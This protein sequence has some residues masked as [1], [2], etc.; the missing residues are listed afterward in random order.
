MYHRQS[1]DGGGM[2]PDGDGKRQWD[3]DKSY[4]GKW[5]VYDLSLRSSAAR[6]TAFA[7]G[8]WTMSINGQNTPQGSACPTMDGTDVIY[9]T[10]HWQFQDLSWNYSY[11]NFTTWKPVLVMAYELRTELYVFDFTTDW[12][13][14]RSGRFVISA[15]PYSAQ[16][17]SDYYCTL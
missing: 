9:G 7:Y 2:N 13:G 11:D 6:P 15:R 1:L 3:A 10:F 16:G 14:T 4:S 5:T 12:T 8:E 17:Y